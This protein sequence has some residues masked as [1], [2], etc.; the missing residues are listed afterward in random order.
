MESVIDGLELKKILQTGTAYL[1]DIRE[2]YMYERG[3][4]GNAL[5]IP[6][7]MLREFPEKYLDKNILYYVFCES[8]TISLRLANYLNSLGYQ[9]VSVKDGYDGFINL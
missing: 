5:N 6:F 2:H 1:I 8:G 4:I 3:T 9:I 7:R